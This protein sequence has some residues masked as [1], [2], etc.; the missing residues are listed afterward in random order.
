MQSSIHRLLQVLCIGLGTFPSAIQGRLKALER[1]KE[2]NQQL[3]QAVR[4]RISMLRGQVQE[5]EQL[6]VIIG[7]APGND[8]LRDNIES[9]HVVRKKFQRINALSALISRTELLDLQ[10]N[11]DVLYVDQDVMVYPD[12]EDDEPILYGLNMVQ[13]FDPVIPAFNIS[14]ACSDP[15][16]FKVGIVDSGLAM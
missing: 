10:Q 6:P 16:S 2:Y 4:S 5:E 12:E 8:E 7:F 13:A 11:P 1:Q 3:L 14:A 15:N 9:R